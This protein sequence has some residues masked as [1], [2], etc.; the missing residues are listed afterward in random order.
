M[1]L[2]IF[3]MWDEEAK[4]EQ[5]S[6]E[7]TGATGNFSSPTIIRSYESTDA[8]ATGARSY[9]ASTL[10]T[11]KDRFEDLDV[12][13]LNRTMAARTAHARWTDLFTEGPSP[14]L[15]SLGKGWDL[16]E[17]TSEQWTGESIAEMRA[18]HRH[19]AVITKILHLKRPS[20]VPVLDS[21][22]ID[23]LGGRGKSVEQ[24]LEHLRSVGRSNRDAL[25]QIQTHL[26]SLAGYDQRPIDRTT[27]RI[28]D[29][30]LWSTHPASVL[31]PLLARWHTTL[32]VQPLA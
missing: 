28:L 29:A 4:A 32:A 6:R 17:A 10:T 19:H 18:A 21:L 14:I 20:L 8:S 31:Y 15:A 24:V 2:G 13:A 3:G 25:R 30:L 5:A 9:D 11:N 26:V 27:V 7:L 1:V 16:I 12:T 23:Q 22:V